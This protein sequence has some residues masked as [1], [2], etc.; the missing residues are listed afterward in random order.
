MKKYSINNNT[1]INDKAIIIH[2]NINTK[3]YFYF[4]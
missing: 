1:N 4:Y 3:Y 2:N